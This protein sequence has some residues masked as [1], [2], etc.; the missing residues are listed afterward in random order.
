MAHPTV[1]PFNISKQFLWSK[2][3][4]KTYFLKQRYLLK[5]ET[6]THGQTLM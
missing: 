6:K 1:V 3:R 2:N 4:N 5:D